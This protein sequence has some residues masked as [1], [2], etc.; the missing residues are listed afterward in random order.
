MSDSLYL[1]LWF[2]SFEESEMLPGV[3]RVMQQF[4]WSKEEPGI[5]DISVHPVSWNEATI[6]EQRFRPGVPPEQA[7]TVA[8]DLLHEDY[9]YVFAG[10]WDLWT[11][12]DSGEWTLRPTLVRFL[13]RGEQFEE[14]EAE[15]QGDVEVDFGP[16]SPF[17]YEELELTPELEKRVQANV[18]ML[19]GFIGRVEK[20]GEATTRLLWSESDENLAQ[21]LISRLQKVQ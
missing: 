4:P 11:P 14:G 5:T 8:F 2:S 15:T 6:L 10:N 3:L 16:D 19:V 1:S 7:V 17:L 12:R 9:A 21:K 18:E 13:V 20:T